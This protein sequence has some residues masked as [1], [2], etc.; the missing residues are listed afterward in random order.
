MT[1][2]YRCECECHKECRV[3]VTLSCDCG[4]PV[5]KPKPCCPPPIPDQPGIINIPQE[6]PPPSPRTSPTPVW[7]QPGRPTPGTPAE[8]NWFGN[9]IGNIVRKG[10]TFGP[11]QDEYLPFIVVRASSADRGDRA[12]T[13]TFWESPDIYVLPNVDASAAPLQPPQLGL[14]ATAG[15]P[16]TLYAHVW[17]V[18]NAPAYRARVEFYWFNPSLG[19][20]RADS[21][22]IGA[23]YVDIGNRFT[24]FS[25]WKEVTTSY[26]TWLSR[27]AHVVVRCPATWFP[28]YENGGHECLVVRVFEPFKDPLSVDQFS[29]AASRQVAQRNIAVALS[30]SPAEIDIPLDLGYAKMPG[31]VTVDVEIGSPVSMD[32]LRLYVGRNGTPITASG[33]PIVAGLLPPSIRGAHSLRIGDVE[34]DCRGPLLRHSQTFER[35]CDPVQIGFHASVKSLKRDEAYVARIRQ[36]VDGDVVG[37]YS[38]VLL[39]R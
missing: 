27:G 31:T 20:A 15:A 23:A 30:S 6:N 37:G 38:V 19:I 5:S 16:N 26:G 21:H 4:Q 36:R 29:A 32:Y 24:H 34:F 39:G 18:G 22:F 7:Q 17:N 13:G 12:L 1:G 10:P 35:G 3:H 33:E 2:G 28:V 11:R 8:V 14:P 9:Q 25:A